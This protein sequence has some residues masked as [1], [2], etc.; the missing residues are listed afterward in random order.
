MPRRSLAPIAAGEALTE[1]EENECQE[2]NDRREEG[3]H[4][5]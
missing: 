1:P 4:R 2:Q 5:A 3:E